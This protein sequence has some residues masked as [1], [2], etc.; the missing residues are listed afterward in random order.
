MTEKNSIMYR[1]IC[2]SFFIHSLVDGSNR[3]FLWTKSSKRKVIPTYSFKAMNPQQLVISSLFLTI[4]QLNFISSWF[5]FYIFKCKIL[6]NFLL[7]FV[8]LIFPSVFYPYLYFLHSMH[9]N[10]YMYTHIIYTYICMWVYIIGSTPAWLIIYSFEVFRVWFR[11]LA[12]YSIAN[13]VHHAVLDTVM[14]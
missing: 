5:Y 3:L 9:C 2:H 1:Y 6:R 14:I 4:W 7:K 12:H 10:I 13:K 11:K 8:F